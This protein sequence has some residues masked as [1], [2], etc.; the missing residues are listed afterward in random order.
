[1]EAEP[2]KKRGR[3]AKGDAPK[4]AAKAAPKKNA[5]PKAKTTAKAKTPAKAAPAVPEGET[6][7][8]KRRGRPPK[9]GETTKVEVADEAAAEQLEGELVETAEAEG[10]SKR[11]KSPS[12]KRGRP[13]KAKGKA[14]T[15]VTEV[16]DEEED[17]DEEDVAEATNEESTKQYWLMKAE[18]EDRQE[19][20][21]DGS[22]VSRHLSAASCITDI[23]SSTPS[24]PS[25]I[26]AP[27]ASRSRG[28]VFA[29]RPRA[30]T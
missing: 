13:I 9:G 7:P 18:Q 23:A 3:P 2:P 11:T 20:L 22:V 29:T 5:T 17:L 8:P 1:M 16:V 19:T 12:K 21:S 25:T 26:S 24:S 14:K 15:A 4:P 10:P 6:A 27:R 30:R 28:T